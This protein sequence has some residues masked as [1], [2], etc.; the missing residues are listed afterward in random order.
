MPLQPLGDHLEAQIYETF[1][2][3]PIKYSSY[4]Q[5]TQLAIEQVVKRISGREM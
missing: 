2:K 4:K 3:D 5:A 1:E